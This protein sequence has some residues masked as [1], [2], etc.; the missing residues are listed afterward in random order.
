MLPAF[1]I[2][3]S[4]KCTHTTQTYCKLK[5]ATKIDVKNANFPQ[6]GFVTTQQP[7]NGKNSYIK[8]REIIP[9]HYT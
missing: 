9:R 2:C 8:G 4:R 7:L 5:N 3:A 6:H 1:S